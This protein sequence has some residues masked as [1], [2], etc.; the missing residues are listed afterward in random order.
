MILQ[1][2]ASDAAILGGLCPAGTPT[3]LGQLGCFLAEWEVVVVPVVVIAV[4][5][6]VVWT[7]RT[8]RSHPGASGHQGSPFLVFPMQSENRASRAPTGD[9]TTRPGPPIEPRPAVGTTPPSPTPSETVESGQVRYER[10][11]D[12]TLQLL[13]GRLEVL[14]NGQGEAGEEIRFVRAPDQ[15]PEVTFGRSEGVPYRHVQLHSPTV[16]RIHA[17]MRFADGRWTLRNESSTNPTLLNGS[18]LDSGVEA[19]TLKD[20]DRIEMGEAV[21]RFHQPSVKDRL[22]LRSSWYTDQGRRPTNQDSVVVKSLSRG[23]ELLA[24]CDGM[25]SHAL[26]RLASHAAM[27]TL[28]KTLSEGGSLL[29]A[30]ESANR[31]VR[32]EMENNEDGAGLGTTLVA[33]LRTEHEYQ[34]ANVGDSRAYRIDPQGVHRITQDHSFVAEVVREGRMSKEEAGR[35]PWRSAITRHLGA[36]PEVEVDLFGAYPTHEPHIVLLCSDGLH[37]ILNDQA[38]KA[39]VRELTDIRDVARELGEEALR[40]GGD[41]NVAVAAIEFQEGLRA[42]RE[43]SP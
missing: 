14:A 15:E 35:S 16:S 8:R 10:S 36:E 17:R 19:P 18:P 11:P 41:D 22:P 23:R 30:V 27:D 24:V 43:S 20:G 33:L 28:V 9:R 21:F 26:G 38:I 34:I 12:G 37:G 42:I 29:E 1:Q 3:G 5:V 6:G 4:I 13:P 2:S 25:G 7:V 39:K 31:A 40:K 32:E